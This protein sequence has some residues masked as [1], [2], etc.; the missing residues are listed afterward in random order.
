MTSST[1]WW[2]FSKVKKDGKIV[3]GTC[4]VIGC[5]LRLATGGNTSHLKN[6]IATK[7][8]AV[9]RILERCWGIKYDCV[10]VGVYSFV[11][12]VDEYNLYHRE[13]QLTEEQVIEIKSQLAPFL[14]PENRNTKEQTETVEVIEISDAN[15]PPPAA[16]RQRITMEDHLLAMPPETTVHGLVFR[17]IIDSNLPA[18]AVGSV[19]LQNLQMLL[20]ARPLGRRTFGNMRSKAFA[21][22]MDKIVEELR[23]SISY[24]ITVDGWINKGKF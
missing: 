8:S 6:H 14:I 1:I 10:C 19:H 9:W 12:C 24:S 23:S 2:A 22:T 11:L 18:R 5:N 16:K 13:G 21:E 15:P 20:G 17:H 4:K 3:A 7:H